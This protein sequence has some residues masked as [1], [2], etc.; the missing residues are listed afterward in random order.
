[1]TKEGAVPHGSD[2]Y[3]LYIFKCLFKV[4][5]YI[6]N[7]L[8][9]DGETDK[10]LINSAVL[11]LLCGKLTV[12]GACRVQAAGAAIGNVGDYRGKLETVHKSDG[13]LSA[14]VDSQ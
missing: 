6:L 9:S 4:S 3:R 5:Y 2:I 13:R 12:C 10:V 11:K 7:V 14:S 8:D 1:M